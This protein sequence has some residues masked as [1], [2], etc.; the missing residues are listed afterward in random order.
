MNVTA[1]AKTNHVGVR[2]PIELAEKIKELAQ[3]HHRTLTG[4]IIHALTQYVAAFEKEDP[5][6]WVS[7][8]QGWVE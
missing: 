8:D 4:E 7:V 1:K 5:P 2:M 6:H 3:R